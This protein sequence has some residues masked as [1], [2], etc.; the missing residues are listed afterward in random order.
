MLFLKHYST[1]R[2]GP[3]EE[4]LCIAKNKALNE[5]WEAVLNLYREQ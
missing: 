5:A 2:I 1:T 4:I 3:F